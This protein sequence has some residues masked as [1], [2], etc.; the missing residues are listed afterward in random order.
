[1]TI[2]PLMMLHIYR[3]GN[4]IA[5]SIYVLRRMAKGS[6][7]AKSICEDV[8]ESQQMMTVGEVATRLSRVTQVDA[9]TIARQL[10]GWIQTGA[11]KPA[12]T[13]ARGTSGAIVAALF[14][15]T[16][17]CKARLVMALVATSPGKGEADLFEKVLHQ[18]EA[19]R[20]ELRVTGANKVINFDA[21]V[22]GTRRG[23]NWVLE[24]VIVRDFLAGGMATSARWIVDGNRDS[25]SCLDAMLPK[26]EPLGGAVEA[27]I[28]L[29]F[30]KLTRPLLAAK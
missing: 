12:K 25:V 18:A 20:T 27:V 5:T 6:R 4:L 30:S 21:A 13:E 28:Q 23:E 7:R 11:L 2:I 3:R 17:L 14:D 22:A 15:E 1:V 10:R 19:G 29:P 16:A 26:N 8:M 9:G 24:V